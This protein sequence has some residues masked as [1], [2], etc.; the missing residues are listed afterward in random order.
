MGGLSAVTAAGAAAAA[1]AADE[2]R[3]RDGTVVSLD[4][5]RDKNV[6]QLRKLNS[7]LFPVRYAESYYTDAIAAGE[8]A[9]LG[10][11]VA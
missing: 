7:V 6:Q 2:K 3:A 1:E 11:L 8:F 4:S 5:V 10:K 9:R